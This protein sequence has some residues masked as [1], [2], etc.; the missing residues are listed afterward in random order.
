MSMGGVGPR[1][2]REDGSRR[3]GVIAK[4][5]MIGSRIIE[6]D[7]AFD[8]AQAQNLCVKVQVPLRIRSD[9]SYVVKAG[10]RA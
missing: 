10:D 5:E 6:I 4:V 7:G 3:A 8:E 9:C 1:K 2:E